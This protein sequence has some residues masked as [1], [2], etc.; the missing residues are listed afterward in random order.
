ML[1]N[2]QVFRLNDSTMRGVT[3]A[4]RTGCWA[5]MN[6]STRFRMRLVRSLLKPIIIWCF[7]SPSCSVG[8]SSL[9]STAQVVSFAFGVSARA[10][11]CILFF[12]G[13]RLFA[14]AVVCV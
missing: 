6:A 7:S 12:D 8:V 4:G 10:A 13:S 3:F 9:A 11:P 1:G 5:D 2:E 14:V